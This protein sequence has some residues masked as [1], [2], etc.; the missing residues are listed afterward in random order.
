MTHPDKGTEM[1]L[2]EQENVAAHAAY[3]RAGGERGDDEKDV[4]LGVRANDAQSGPF[5][6]HR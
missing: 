1:F 4:R 2:T 6:C 3:E 5:P